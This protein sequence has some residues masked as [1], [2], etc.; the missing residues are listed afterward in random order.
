MSNEVSQFGSDS[1]LPAVKELCFDYLKNL[2]KRPGGH[3]LKFNDELGSREKPGRIVEEYHRTAIQFKDDIF[4]QNASD[5]HIDYHKI[6]ALYI[7]AFLLYRPFYLDIPAETK[8]PE[9][10]L[11]TMLANEY[12]ALPYLEAIFRGWNE[13]FTGVLRIPVH[14]RDSFIK[15]LYHYKKDLT[16][17]DYASL[18]NVIYLID[19]N[20]FQRTIL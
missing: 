14:Y 19:Q 1:W 8:F 10:C 17:L 15:L 13:D 6:A 9:L 7:R 5:S 4:G 18:S 20:Y 2:Q 12:F 16:T 11:Y 3:Y